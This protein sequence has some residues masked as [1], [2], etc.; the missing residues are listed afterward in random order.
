MGKGSE[1]VKE[2]EYQK[3]LAKIATEKWEIARANLQPLEDM[4]IVDTAKGVTAEQRGKVSGA[5]GLSSQSQFGK[6]ADQTLKGLAAGGV[7]PTSGKAKES[8][9][10]ISISGSA[11]R[12]AGEVSGEAGLQSNQMSKELN[13]LRVGSG[14]AT[15]AQAGIADVAARSSQQA[16]FDAQQSIQRNQGLRQLAGTAG[17]IAAGYYGTGAKGSQQNNFST[18][19]GGIVDSVDPNKYEGGPQWA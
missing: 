3:E 15:Q 18:S 10:D 17:G 7:D 8:L 6:A 11:S 19:K 2:T 5:V 13:L 16:A 1:K 14:E 9:S 12:T 4:M